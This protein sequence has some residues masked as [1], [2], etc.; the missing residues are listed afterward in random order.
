MH[1]NPHISVPQISKVLFLFVFLV[2][3]CL[4]GIQAEELKSIFYFNWSLSQRQ[5]QSSEQTL[6]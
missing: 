4:A 1:I 5:A 3:V 2:T 6:A